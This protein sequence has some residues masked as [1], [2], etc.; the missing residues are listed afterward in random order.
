[1]KILW[2]MES[3]ADRDMEPNCTSSTDRI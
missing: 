3:F 1:L 2:K